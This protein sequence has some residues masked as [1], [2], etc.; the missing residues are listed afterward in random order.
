VP[1]LVER[2]QTRVEFV[3]CADEIE[4][5][6]AAWSHLEEIVPL[7]GNHFFGTFDGSAYRACVE[8]RD[9]TFGLEPG[10]IPGG[11]Y[12]RSRLRGEP[13][14]VYEL[15]APTLDEL[16][17]AVEV[18]GTRPFIEHYRRHDEIDLLVPVA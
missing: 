3:S 4:K 10:T 9:R 15:I 14:A 17:A 13:P 1:E 7:R 2:E 5:I 11:L 8:V 16:A 18:D 12:A 6:R